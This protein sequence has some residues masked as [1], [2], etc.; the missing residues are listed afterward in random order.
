MRTPLLLC[1]AL[2]GALYATGAT[3]DEKTLVGEMAEQALFEIASTQGDPDLVDRFLLPS[4]ATLRADGAQTL[5]RLAN[6][7][8]LKPLAELL[9]DLDEPVAIAAAVALAKTPG[10]TEE[11]R[12]A[13]GTETRP[14]VRG[15]ILRALGFHGETGDIE[16]LIMNLADTHAEVRVGAAH[17]LGTMGRRKVQGLARVDV[18]RALVTATQRIELDPRSHRLA[19]HA[20]A[21][22]DWTG[23]PE[24]TGSNFADQ[25]RRHGD[26]H[27]RAWYIRGAKTATSDADWSALTDDLAE[28]SAS[29]VRIAVARGIGARPGIAPLRAMHTLLTDIERPVRLAAF[30]AAANLADQQDIIDVVEAALDSELND[31]EL[32]ALGVAALMEASRGPA[33][34]TLVE[35]KSVWMREIATRYADEQQLQILAGDE[36]PTVRTNAFMALLKTAI[37][38]SDTDALVALANDS[39][40]AAD[41]RSAVA[42]EA[43]GSDIALPDTANVEVPRTAPW[44]QL[45]SLRDVLT[46][47]S[48]RIHTSRGEFRL[49]LRPDLAPATVSVWS[50][51]ATDGFYNGLIFHRVVSD[52]V[53]QGGDPRGDGWGGPGFQIPD[54][55]SAASYVT[56][57]VGMATSG[58]NTGGSQWFI[59]LSPQPHLD[60]NYTLF[61]EVSYGMD[62]V[63]RLQRGDEIFAIE[64]EP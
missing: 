3:A 42:E 54:E 17:A 48:A 46:L 10:A 44:K 34:H 24:E 9:T 64:L 6:K 60:Q 57:S 7:D 19:A 1:V 50:R 41:V 63:R 40:F 59:T 26:R 31:P 53:V 13:L 38:A 39:R 37:E 28:D 43:K 52:F 4:N 21:R 49:T 30:E 29:G 27:V 61:A 45:P 11:L 12:D 15:A 32:E 56:G 35:N 20:I 62:I 8:A 47:R 14:E 18:A 5:G 36:E 2:T 16:T 51:L 25:A 22:I 55:H 23:V 33:V 58:P